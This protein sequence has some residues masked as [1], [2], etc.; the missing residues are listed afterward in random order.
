MPLQFQL[1]TQ[2]AVWSLSWLC[3]DYHRMLPD[4][5]LEPTRW[6]KACPSRFERVLSLIALSLDAGTCK[7]TFDPAWP[8]LTL[9]VGTA[10]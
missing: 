3:Q 9:L 10:S 4:R 8:L 7:E 6:A 1:H 5:V 2:S